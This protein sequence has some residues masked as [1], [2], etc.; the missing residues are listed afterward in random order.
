MSPDLVSPSVFTGGVL[1]PCDHSGGFLW[2]LFNRSMSLCWE[3]QSWMQHSRLGEQGDRIPSLA[4]LLMLL[5]MQH[6]IWLAFWDVRA[7]GHVMLKFL[8]TNIPKCSGLHSIHFVLS[9]YLCLGLHQPRCRSLHGDLL[10]FM[11]IAQGHL[12]SLSRSLWVGS[13]PFL[14]Y[15]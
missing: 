15:M 2:S 11:K 12:S 10:N 4:L 13:L 8:S 1:Q 5:W 7:H 9:L 6:R 3:S 14:G